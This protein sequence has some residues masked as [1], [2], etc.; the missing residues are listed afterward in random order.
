MASLSAVSI[1]VVNRLAVIDSDNALDKPGCRLDHDGMARGDHRSSCVVSMLRVSDHPCPD[2]A[3]RL[4]VVSVEIGIA[5][6][7]SDICAQ[8]ESETL[9][10]W[11]IP[12]VIGFDRRAPTHAFRLM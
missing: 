3:M 12:R 6:D 11:L 1:N 8:S 4:M 7:L 9:Q 5:D 2:E 10:S